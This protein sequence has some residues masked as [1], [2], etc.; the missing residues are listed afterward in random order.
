MPVD[1]YAV[2]DETSFL[3]IA[4]DLEKSVDPFM[5]AMARSIRALLPIIVT[6]SKNEAKTHWNTPV[7]IE[8]SMRAISRTLGLAVYLVAVGAS[9]GQPALVS[10]FME[11]IMRDIDDAAAE[12]RRQMTITPFPNL[13]GN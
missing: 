5:R 2:N 4:A 1:K 11:V 6:H 7:G 12:Q 9:R 13:N 10:K 8:M 3:A